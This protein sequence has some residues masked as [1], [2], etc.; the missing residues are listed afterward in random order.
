MTFSRTKHHH[1]I[2]IVIILKESI[3]YLTWV[4]PLLY[5]YQPEDSLKLPNKAGLTET[6]T[7]SKKKISPTSTLL[8]YLKIFIS[9]FNRQYSSTLNKKNFSFISF[10]LLR[11]NLHSATS[12]WYNSKIESCHKTFPFLFFYWS[13]KNISIVQ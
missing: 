7:H 1:T 13:I 9:K 8:S 12:L 6:P 4:G 5:I 2:L 10:S 11:I 3:Q